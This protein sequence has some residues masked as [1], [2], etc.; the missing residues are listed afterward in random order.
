[1]AVERNTLWISYP[2]HITLHNRYPPVTG[3]ANAGQPVESKANP[4]LE[5]S[6]WGWAIDPSDSEIL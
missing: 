2:S 5:T 6:I 3:D 4:Y 1:M